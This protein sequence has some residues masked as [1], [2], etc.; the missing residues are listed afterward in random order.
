MLTLE[1]TRRLTHYLYI[2]RHPHLLHEAPVPQR[3]NGRDMQRVRVPFA[4]AVRDRFEVIGNDLSADHKHI[5]GKFAVDRAHKR[6]QPALDRPPGV[7]WYR[8]SRFLCAS[9]MR[10][11][12]RRTAR[13]RRDLSP[14][15]HARIRSAR[16]REDRSA[17][18][19]SRARRARP[20]P[21]PSVA[22]PD[23]AKTPR[24]PRPLPPN[25]SHATPR[26]HPE[27]EAPASATR[28]IQSRHTRW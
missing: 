3:A 28:R 13:E 1:A 26:P 23:R 24:D 22:P 10:W 25:S 27:S 14:R 11:G 16:P 6:L 7:R 21:A 8:R 2:Q 20:P 5:L 18:A 4:H 19:P 9:S 15:M 17:R 12:F